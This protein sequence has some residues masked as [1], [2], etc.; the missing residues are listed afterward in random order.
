MLT[1]ECILDIQ[2][3]LGE[4]PIWDDRTETLFW[5]DINQAALHRYNPATHRHDIIALS[6]RIGSFSLCQTGPQLLAA[7]ETGYNW[8]NPINGELKPIFDPEADLPDNRFNDGRCDRKGRFWAG[9]MCDP[10]REPVGSLYRLDSDLKCHRIRS[11]LTVPNS[12]AWSPNNQIMYFTDTPTRRILAFDYDLESGTI[13]G[14][15][16]FADLSAR[17]GRPD[18]SAMDADGCLWNASYGGNRVI[19]LRPDG[20]IDR[21]I[22][23]PARNVTCCAFGGRDLDILYITTARQNLSITD[24]Q[25]QSLAG[26]LFAVRPGVSGLPEAR[27]AGMPS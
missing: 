24:L 22:T 17:P 5:V 18:G 14:E 8:L 19:R 13:K 11:Q 7:G 15:R 20:H 6:A 27:F 21:E 12:I 25:H 10:R 16:L 9:T 3:S 2:N 4:C 1:A 23:V 26:G